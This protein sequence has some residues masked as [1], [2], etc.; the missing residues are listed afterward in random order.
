[1]MPTEDFP[2][3]IGGRFRTIRVLGRGGM[4]VVYE[5]EHVHTE[6]RL[7]LKLLSAQ[8]NAAERPSTGSSVR[9]ERPLRSRASTW[10]G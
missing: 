3:I 9:H 8:S 6:E 7:A 4:G 10:S 2:A 1:M 5:V